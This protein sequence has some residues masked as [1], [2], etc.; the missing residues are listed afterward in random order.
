MN[1]EL[2]EG[3]TV[4]FK[5]YSLEL[6]EVRGRNVKFVRYGGDVV[7]CGAAPLDHTT[8]TVTSVSTL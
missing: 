5:V 4:T 7:S 1:G 2:S 3:L 6:S 8:K